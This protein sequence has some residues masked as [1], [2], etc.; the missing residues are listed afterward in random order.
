MNSRNPRLRWLGVGLSLIAVFFRALEIVVA[1]ELRE[2]LDV[3]QVTFWRFFL[4]LILLVVV[5]KIRNT[6]IM[7]LPKQH[8]LLFWL[9]NLT[10]IGAQL[11]FTLGLPFLS[12]GVATAVFYTHPLMITIGAVLVYKYRVTVVSWTAIF[13]ATLGA[14]FLSSP[15]TTSPFHWAVVIILIGA[16]LAATSDLLLNRLTILG[17]PSIEMAVTY[18]FAGTLVTAP[19]LSLTVRW[20]SASEVSLLFIMAGFGLLFQFLHYQSFRYA[21]PASLSPIK[22]TA[23]A[24]NAL[25]DIFIYQTH[26]PTIQLIGM[27]L[28]GTGAALSGLSHNRAPQ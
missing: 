10:G 1:R 18:F 6:R 25:I 13:I 12:V 19:T 11:S 23:L 5:L 9:R 26:I 8:H 22:P 2:N 4:G 16:I 17:Y 21:E 7:L 20:P 27:V 24:W 28:I 14:I 3:F 15:T